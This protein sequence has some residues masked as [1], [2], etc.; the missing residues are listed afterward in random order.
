MS[1]S[2][3]VSMRGL[4]FIPWI[5]HSSLNLSMVVSSI[6]S[7]TLIFI[8]VSP[9]LLGIFLVCILHIFFHILCGR[10]YAVVV[11][12][13]FLFYQNIF[14]DYIFLCCMMRA[15]LLDIHSFHNRL[16][17]VEYYHVLLYYIHILFLSFKHLRF[18]V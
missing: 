5:L 16:L 14:F 2:S 1:F 7:V 6:D 11:G 4:I 10:G 9:L 18:Y 8:V 15:I 3:N 17:H 13:V 12:M